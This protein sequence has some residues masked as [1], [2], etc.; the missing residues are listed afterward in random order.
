MPSAKRERKRQ[1]RAA[2]QEAIRAAERRRARQRQVVLFVV[3]IAVV[4][5]LGTLLFRG[6]GKKSSSASSCKPNTSLKF[7]K[8]DTVIKPSKTYKAVVKTDIGSF[9]VA[10][11]TTRTPI[12]ANNF[13]FLAKKGFYDCVSFHRV[14]PDFVV[15]GGDPTGSG[16]GGPGYQFA[17]E[18]LQGTTYKAGDLAMANSGAN[19]NGSQ[20]FVILS[21]NGAKTLTQ[22]VGGSANY[23]DF[24][25]VTS[26]MDVLHKIEADGGTQG[27]NGTDIKKSHHIVNITIEES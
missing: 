7:A 10:F 20:F 17:D 9:T 3:L 1:G 26:G 18:S 16:S 19:T 27:G 4:F 11:D 13:I 8:A 22:A 24:A 6:G 21:D 14:I 15:Q 23:T 2:R 5:G 25:H 12:T